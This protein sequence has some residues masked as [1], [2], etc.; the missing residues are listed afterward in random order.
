LPSDPF[1]GTYADFQGHGFQDAWSEANPDVPGLTCCQ[2]ETLTNMPSAYYKRVD[3]VLIHGDLN[4]V[5][6]L[7]YGAKPSDRT[8]GLWPSDHAGVAVRLKTGD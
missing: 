8:M 6:A 5:S 1:Y 3:L 4:V 7:R 2:A